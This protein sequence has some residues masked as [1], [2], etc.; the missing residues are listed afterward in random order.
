MTYSKIT[1]YFAHEFS[2]CSQKNSRLRSCALFR[3]V[4][5]KTTTKFQQF[6]FSWPLRFAHLYQR[7]TDD[8]IMSKE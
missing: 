3:P 8:T 7:Q 4:F 2:N 6:P 5:M 1:A